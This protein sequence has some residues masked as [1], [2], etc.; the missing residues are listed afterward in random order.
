MNF[1]PFTFS[2]CANRDFSSELEDHVAWYL[3]NP[4]VVASPLSPKQLGSIIKNQVQQINNIVQS[5]PDDIHV[6]ERELVHLVHVSDNT[7]MSVRV[8]VHYN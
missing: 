1:P 3:L 8:T 7:R 5:S 2:F 6:Y 4:V